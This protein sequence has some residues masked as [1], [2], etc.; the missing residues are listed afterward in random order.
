MRYLLSLSCVI[1]SLGLAESFIGTLT[2]RRRP[3][4]LLLRQANEDKPDS[5]D[6][7]NKEIPSP[8]EQS[9]SGTDDMTF[10]EKMGKFLDR[11]FFNPKDVKE[12]S[13]LKWFADLVENDYATAEA[14][15]TSFFIAV[16]VLITQELVRMQVYGDKYVP[17]QKLGDGSLF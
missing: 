15:Y 3:A 6:S 12:G 17:F 14:L 9:I 7:S 1:I 2:Q 13:P 11:E 10:E 16:M 5:E 4:W 8:L